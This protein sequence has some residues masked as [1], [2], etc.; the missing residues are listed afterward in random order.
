[1]TFDAETGVAFRQAHCDRVPVR[2]EPHLLIVSDNQ[3]LKV[4][5]LPFR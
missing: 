1:M 4:S 5:S 3:R 2:K